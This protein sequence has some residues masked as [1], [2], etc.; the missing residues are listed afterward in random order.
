MFT[1]G[2]L[3][4]RPELPVM[5]GAAST[6]GPTFWPAFGGQSAKSSQGAIA[7][8]GK[9]DRVRQQRAQRPLRMPRARRGYAA[10]A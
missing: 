1:H 5:R 7:G 4:A 6:R 3:V 9:R 10:K 2:V 8:I